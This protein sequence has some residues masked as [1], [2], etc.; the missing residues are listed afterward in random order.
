MTYIFRQQRGIYW[1]QQSLYCIDTEH[2]KVFQL[3]C[4]VLFTAI[5]IHNAANSIHGTQKVFIK[6]F[7]N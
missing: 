6:L 5:I 3:K 4:K 7:F 1:S 2:L